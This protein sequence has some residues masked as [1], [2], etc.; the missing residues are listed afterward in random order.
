MIPFIQ[1]D[2]DP[3]SPPPFTF[4][5][6]TVRSFQ[7][8]ADWD[9]M[10]AVCDAALNIGDFADRG[11]LY[12][13]L[14]GFPYVSLDILTYPRM[15]DD[16]L[17]FR[18][19]GYSEQHECYFRIFVVKYV[20]FSGFLLPVDVSGFF[21]YMFVDEPWSMIS[22]REVLGL[23][24]VL[25]EFAIP[26]PQ[27]DIV[28][29]TEVLNPYNPAT[30][31]AVK[32]AVTVHPAPAAAAAPQ[33]RPTYEWPWGF[34][35]V[36]LLDPTHQTLLQQ[37]PLALAGGFSTV[38]IKQFRDG[39]NDAYACY[40]ALLRGA[41]TVSNVQLQSVPAPSEIDIP[42]YD[43]LQIASNLGLLPAAGSTFYKPKWEYTMTCDMGYSDVTTEYASSA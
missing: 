18:G 1:R 17:D 8:E 33:A 14:P 24:K 22:G 2:S 39:G 21:P 7:I 15:E 30:K 9:K 41:F 29:S 3:Q 38:Q 40:Q 4:P 28:V 34:L 42:R 23:P 37:A 35:D 13:P 16:N 36:G 19:R 32:P 11:F 26:D 20:L 27:G 12:R 6:V 31:L 25:A 43:S 10:N 5:G